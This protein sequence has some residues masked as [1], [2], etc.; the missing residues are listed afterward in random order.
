MTMGRHGGKPPSEPPDPANTEPWSQ[1]DRLIHPAPWVDPEPSEPTNPDLWGSDPFYD[2]NLSDRPRRA[3]AL[4]AVVLAVV[5]SA[6]IGA[7][8]WMFGTG[9]A[10]TAPSVVYRTE[11]REATVTH[12]VTRPGKGKVSY[13]TTTA[14]ARPT[15]LP[16]PTVFVTSPARPAPV[17]T[18]TVKVVTTVRA[19]VRVTKEVRVPGPVVTVTVEAQDQVNGDL[20]AE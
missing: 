8:G 1:E 13:R 7:V 16:A 6:V 10:E 18:K 19:T 9:T 15:L 14:T 4:M 20:P 5:V 12:T 11:Q 2:T 3:P 17:V